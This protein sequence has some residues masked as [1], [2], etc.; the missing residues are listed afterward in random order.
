MSDCEGAFGRALRARHRRRD[1]R[2]LA[3]RGREA[4]QQEQAVRR[5]AGGSLGGH[6]LN[7]VG[8][9]C[10]NDTADPAIKETKRLMEQLG[11]DM[12]IG[13]LSGDEAVAV[14]NYA[15][16]HPTKTFVNG[17]AG[18]QD[19]T[20]QVRRRTSSAST[21]TA[22]SGTPGSAT[23]LYKKLGWR[24]AAIIMDDYSFGWTSGGGLHRRLLRRRRQDHEAGVPAAQHHRL[25]VLRPAAAGTRRGRRVLLGRRR[26]RHGPRSRRSSRPTGTIKPEQLSGNLFFFIVGRRQDDRHRAERVRTS[27][28]SAP[29]R[30]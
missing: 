26:H 19:P 30:A 29:L 8:I 10:A 24:K 22:L 14:A 11:A 13:P 27:A 28:G 21:V 20:L 25:L 5:L 1:H 18:S 15:K 17:T 3:V 7:L 6:P 9:G 2:V 16:Q 12:M 4:E 23:S